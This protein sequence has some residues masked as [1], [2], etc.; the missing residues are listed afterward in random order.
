MRKYTPILAFIWYSLVLDAHWNWYRHCKSLC[1]IFFPKPNQKKLGEIMK[2]SANSNIRSR[3]ARQWL[4][5]SKLLIYL[6]P[7][8]ESNGNHDPFTMHNLLQD[9]WH[10]IWPSSTSWTKR[11]WCICWHSIGLTLSLMSSICTFIGWPCAAYI[12]GLQAAASTTPNQ[13]N[14]NPVGSEQ[15]SPWITTIPDV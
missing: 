14:E 8:R 9:W 12:V 2:P 3:G 6:D 13:L 4:T 1:T 11:R 10:Q 7:T 5:K 15:D